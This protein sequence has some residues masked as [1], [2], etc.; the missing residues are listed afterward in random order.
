[1]SEVTGGCHC[2]AVRFTASGDFSAGIECNCSHCDKKGLILAFVPK[3][4]FSLT[5][6]DGAYKTY[7]F[8]RG[9]IDHNFCKTCGV[10]PFGFGKA[11]DGSEMAAINLRCVDNIDRAA[12]NIEN[13]NGRD[14]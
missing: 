10:Q 6:G 4:A 11:P 7:H 9:M 3:A 8:N 5:S 12:L 1:M 2:G 13:V 14:F